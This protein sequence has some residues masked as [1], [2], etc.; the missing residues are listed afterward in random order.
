M[1]NLQVSHYM[2][3]KIISFKKEMT[4]Q[5]AVK[6]LSGSD[7][8]GGPVLDDVG[9]VIGWLSEQDCLDKMLAAS[10][11]CELVALVED[12]MNTP[13]LSVKANYSIV[14]LAQ[15]MLKTTPKIYPVVDDNNIFIGLI[16]RRGVLTAIDKQLESC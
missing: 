10:Y 3:G 8:I 5:Q 11:Y 4:V 13:C 9:H 16:T 7:Y 14:D 1:K 2:A 12:I 15:K 6:K